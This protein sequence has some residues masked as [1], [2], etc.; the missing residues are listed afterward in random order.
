MEES[1]IKQKR[2]AINKQIKKL[3]NRRAYEKRK[4]EKIYCEVCARKVDRLYID[5]HLETTKHKRREE[6]L[7]EQ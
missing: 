2:E 7:N 4:Q 5:K 6:L 3:Q 1:Q